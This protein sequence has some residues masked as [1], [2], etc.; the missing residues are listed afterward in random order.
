MG[1]TNIQT[2]FIPAEFSVLVG[3][4]QP[5]LRGTV[6][7]AAGAASLEEV[8]SHRWALI[9]G[10]VREYTEDIAFIKL[11]SS[12]IAGLAKKALWYGPYTGEGSF[13]IGTGDGSA[14]EDM[15]SGGLQLAVQVCTS[16]YDMSTLTYN[17]KPGLASV[18]IRYGIE[19]PLGSHY[20]I[21]PANWRSQGHETP[22]S[23]R[24]ALVNGI[25]FAIVNKDPTPAD[26]SKTQYWARFPISPYRTN[27]K[28]YVADIQL[29]TENRTPV[30]NAYVTPNS[31]VT[32][33][34]SVKEV[35]EYFT[36]KPQQASF[37][38][39]YYTMT[40]GTASA[41]KTL[42][43]TT[44]TQATIP[45]S[46]VAGAEY[47]YWRVRLTSNDGIVSKWTNYDICSFT[48]RTGKATALSPDGASVTEGE[49]VTFLWEHSSV[50]GIGQGAVQI[51]MKA[52]G[53]TDY[54]TIYSGTTTARRVGVVLPS[55]VTST[56]GQAA[57]RVRTRDTA[58]N[59]SAWSDPLYVYVVAATAAPSVS[60]V[61]TGTARPV[62]TWQSENQ[63]GYRVRVR[64]SAG[65]IV[66]DSGV[67]PGAEQSYQLEE[68]LPNGDYVAAVSIWNQYAIESEEGTK[69]FTVTA[70]SLLAAQ[71]HCGGVKGGVRVRIDFK[72]PAPRLILL[73]DDAP[74]MLLAD[75][76]TTV[77]D[78]G[79]GAGTH[80]YKLRAETND[81]FSESA[82]CWAQP[83]LNCGLLSAADA[84]GDWIELCVNR[85]EAPGHEDN[86]AL[87]ATQRAFQGRALPI[88][89]FTGRREHVHRHT[90]SLRSADDLRRL[91]E[92]ILTQ[93]TLLYRDQ[94][95]RR[96]FCTCSTL[97]VVYDCFS[98]DITLELHEVDYK[99]RVL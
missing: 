89:E 54:V 45:A 63:T 15:L 40:G 52:P 94:Y 9:Q 23:L 35:T 21:Y 61:S 1:L 90:A 36:E 26:S 19:L 72:P 66:Y 17:T 7:N 62:V 93:K 11:S 48:S 27:I 78:W 47:L 56:P 51:Q 34:W 37:E 76:D 43:G 60:S 6:H 73:R 14:Y 67:R 46:D 33:S 49:T 18:D 91:R 53:A 81:S 58:G 85:S 20:T 68:Y 97:P 16:A 71:I 5:D 3:S 83:E 22:E 65:E 13:D 55:T 50:S 74:V 38:V 79:A 69:T 59:W 10:Q 41:T 99:E 39:E 95:G 32:V 98:N 24:Q 70:P 92:L 82:V 64:T 88:T 87:E 30:M 8:V 31:P 80:M 4:A 29:E 28:V 84:P 42:T 75:A 86:L 77:F 44:A 25:A 2:K 57:W 96:Y 12:M